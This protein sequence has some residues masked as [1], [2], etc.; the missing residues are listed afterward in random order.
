MGVLANVSGSA[1][2]VPLLLQEPTITHVLSLFPHPFAP[3]PVS[4]HEVC[5]H[6]EPPNVMF[7]VERQWFF[8]FDHT[9]WFTFF[10]F[11][12]FVAQVKYNRWVRINNG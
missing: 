4:P 9:V 2:E 5:N 12:R 8:L 6:Y 11:G 3:K 10:L 1:V 7:N